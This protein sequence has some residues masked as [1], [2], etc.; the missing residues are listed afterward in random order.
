VNHGGRLF[1]GYVLGSAFLVV[2]RVSLPDLPA[3]VASQVE[4]NT[5]DTFPTLETFGVVEA[6]ESRSR[7]YHHAKKT[8]SVDESSMIEIGRAIQNETNLTLFGFDVIIS[9]SSDEYLVIDVNYFP[10]YVVGLICM[11]SYS[12]NSQVFVGTEKWR[13]LIRSCA[14]T[15]REVFS[16]TDDFGITASFLCANDVESTVDIGKESQ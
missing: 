13:I 7:Q 12:T 14:N 16:Q 9:S 3:G 2:E 11:R 15:S 8:I 4:F 5:Q 10:S 6:E 1:K